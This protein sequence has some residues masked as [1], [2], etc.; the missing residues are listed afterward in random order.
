[1]QPCLSPVWDTVIASYALA[2]A[3]LGP[4]HPALRRAAIWLLGKQTRRSRRL[5]AAQSDAAGRL[6]LRAPQRVLSR[7]RRHLHGADGP[8]ARARRRAGGRSGGGGAARPDLDARHAERRRRLGQLRSGQRQAMA[9]RGSLRRPQRHDRSQHRRHHR[10]RA[11]VAQPLRRVLG[12]ASRGA[13][14]AGFSPPRSDL[15]RCVV[16]T[17]GRELYLRNL[18][19]VAGRGGDRREPRGAVRPSGRS[20][21]AGS[22]ERR[23][24]LGREHREL[25]RS[26]TAWGRRVDTQPDGLGDDGTNRGRRIRHPRRAPGHLPGCSI[27]RTP[28]G[29]GSRRPGPAPDFRRCSI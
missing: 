24:R 28:R 13:A 29:P 25:R 17:L 9:D 8:A 4:E 3:G 19:G 26:V 22:P 21:A 7:R 16:R 15:R 12:G 11:R 5:V 1:M 14:G 2:Q 27:D 18:A 20:M 10:S 6:V 23:R